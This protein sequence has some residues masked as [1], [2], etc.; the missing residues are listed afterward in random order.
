MGEKFSKFEHKRQFS[1]TCLYGGTACKFCRI[2]GGE[3]G[4]PGLWNLQNL[5]AVTP[6]LYGKEQGHLPGAL[7]RQQT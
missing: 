6:Y 2:H 5:H 7:E 4:S 1:G 3:D